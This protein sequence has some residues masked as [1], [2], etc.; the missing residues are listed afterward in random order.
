[1]LTCAL[2]PVGLSVPITTTFALPLTLYYFIL[3][4]RIVRQ[5]FAT[6]VVIGEGGQPGAV[7]VSPLTIA[8]RSHANFLENVPFALILAGLVELNGGSETVLKAAL[9]ALVLARLAHVEL[10]MLAPGG[11]G[12][13]RPVG[14]LTT[15]VVVATLAGYGAYLVKGYWGF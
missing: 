9:G 4:V 8:I 2:P 7:T 3:Q 14:F 11:A 10:G 6:K 13:G 12:F 1:L 5:R 15:N